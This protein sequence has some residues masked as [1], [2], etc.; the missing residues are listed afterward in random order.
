MT[1]PQ[2]NTEVT[3]DFWF[4]PLCPWAWMTRSIREGRATPAEAI[5]TVRQFFE[6]YANNYRPIYHLERVV[7]ALVHG[8]RKGRGGGGGAGGGG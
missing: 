1:D 5:E 8:R 3:A 2:Q 7:L 6:G 4:D